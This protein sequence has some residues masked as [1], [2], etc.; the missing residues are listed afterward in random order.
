TAYALSG[1]EDVGRGIVRFVINH[2]MRQLPR[3]TSS[4]TAERWFLHFVV[5][6]SRRA[7][8]RPPDAAQDVLIESDLAE[9]DAAYAAMVRA[10]RALPA[11]QQEAFIL[12]HGEKL[13]IRFLAVA[14]DCSTKA[15]QMHLHAAEESLRSMTGEAFARLTAQ[16]GKAYMNLTPD[17]DLVRPSI[18]GMVER[19]AW[20]RLLKRLLRLII[21]ILIVAGII[22]LIWKLK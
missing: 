10:L 18:R 11:Q 13:N 5:L 16:M 8:P 3:W 15:A 4:D 17:Q 19:A 7:K 1:R 20:P 14:M 22:Y 9:P 2:A 6:T 21:S 12:H